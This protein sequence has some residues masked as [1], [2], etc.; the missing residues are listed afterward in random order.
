MNTLT[1]RWL[2]VL[3]T[4][5]A[6]QAG[7]QVT[8]SQSREVLRWNGVVDHEIR[9]TLK[10]GD[11]T[12]RDLGTG[13]PRNRQAQVVA[14]VPREAGMLAVDKV[15]G[16]GVVDI[17]DQP[18]A[19]NGWTATLRVLDSLPGYDT[20]RFNVRW[21]SAASGDVAPP[22]GRGRGIFNRVPARTALQWAG[23]IDHDTYIY[24]RPEQ[25]SYST[26]GGNPPTQV[27]ANLI[28]VPQGDVKLLITNFQGRGEAYIAQQPMATNGWVA[29]IRVRD[30][31]AGSSRYRFNITW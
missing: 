6:M 18:T 3:C 25:L 5:L 17:V 13:E 10:G 29:V 4:A 12:I 30:P 2:P 21:Q 28:T 31:L 23:I 8:S 24:L 22:F 9:V 11:V 14:D 20:Y 16:R 19:A 1:A 26:L 7:A 27:E 15:A